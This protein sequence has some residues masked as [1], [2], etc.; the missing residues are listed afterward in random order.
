M[1]AP[2]HLGLLH[3]PWGLTQIM[4]VGRALY[5]LSYLIPTRVLEPNCPQH[6]G[7]RRNEC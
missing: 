3:G 2:P 7:L 6:Y 4:F 1:S 5:Q